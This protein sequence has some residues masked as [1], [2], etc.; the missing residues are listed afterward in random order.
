MTHRKP[1]LPSKTCPVCLRPFD[2]RKKM[3]AVLGI[4]GV[5]LRAMPQIAASADAA[6]ISA[7]S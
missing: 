1:H 4:G 7:A 5:L 3:G 6:L 2:W